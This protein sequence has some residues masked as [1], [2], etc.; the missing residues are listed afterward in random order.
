MVRGGPLI[1][2]DSNK[3][4]DPRAVDQGS[5]DLPW[6]SKI[7]WCFGFEVGRHDLRRDAGESAS[8]A[9]R[10]PAKP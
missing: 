9:S 10:F 2:L 7:K 8:K 6:H 5:V 4:R 1:K 3:R